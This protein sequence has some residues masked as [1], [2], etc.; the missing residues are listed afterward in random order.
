MQHAVHTMLIKA[1]PTGWWGDWRDSKPFQYSSWPMFISTSN[2]S[3]SNAI[4]MR[5]A[6]KNFHAATSFATQTNVEYTKDMAK[7][8]NRSMSIAPNTQKL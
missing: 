5:S 8:F 2:N 6:Q 4:Q 7:S 1:L 3:S